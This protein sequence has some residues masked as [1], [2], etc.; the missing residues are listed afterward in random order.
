MIPTQHKNNLIGFAAPSLKSHEVS[1]LAVELQATKRF[2]AE[3]K[4]K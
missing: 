1:R 4:E 2:S 3:R